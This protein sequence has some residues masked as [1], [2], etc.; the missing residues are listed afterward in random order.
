[1]QYGV[2]HTPRWSTQGGSVHSLLLMWKTSGPHGQA[3]AQVEYIGTN[4]KYAKINKIEKINFGH[5]MA[6]GRL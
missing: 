6:L 5:Y 4:Q 3:L 1:M 2:H